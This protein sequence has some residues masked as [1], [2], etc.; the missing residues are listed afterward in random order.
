MII[1]YI[2][3][4]S[5]SEDTNVAHISGDMLLC[6]CAGIKTNQAQGGTAIWVMRGQKKTKQKKNE[7]KQ[8]NPKPNKQ[9]KHTV[10]ER[11]INKY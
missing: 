11:Q 4:D 3:K 8:K 9:K 7:M 6:L 10:E 5:A 1:K 2:C